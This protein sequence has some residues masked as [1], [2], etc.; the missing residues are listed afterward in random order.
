MHGDLSRLR[1]RF[2]LETY[3]VAV[4][5]LE[6]VFLKIASG[7]SLDGGLA[8]IDFTVKDTEEPIAMSGDGPTFAQQLNAMLLRRVY[9]AKRTS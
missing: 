4:T 1:W 9:D 5:S 2:Q 6:E 8:N 3:G 7:Q